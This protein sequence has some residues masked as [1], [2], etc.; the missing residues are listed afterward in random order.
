M[1]GLVAKYM[2]IGALLT[3]ILWIAEESI[4]MLITHGCRILVLW[5]QKNGRGKLKCFADSTTNWFIVWEKT[6]TM[7]NF[8]VMT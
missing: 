7:G 5:K 4:I 2:N 3:D 1:P 6:I 8:I